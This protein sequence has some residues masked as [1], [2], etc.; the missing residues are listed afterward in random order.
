MPINVTHGLRRVRLV[1]PDRTA[2]L[3]PTFTF[4]DL[5][6]PDHLARL[7]HAVFAKLDLSSFED[8]IR[9]VEGHQGRALT[10]PHMLLTLWCFAISQGVTSAREIFHLT[11]EHAAYRWITSDLPVSHEKLSAF[12]VDHRAQLQAVFTDVLATLLHQGDLDLSLLGQD[13][14]RTRAA[15]SA[16]SFRTLGGLLHCQQQAAL[17]LKAVLAAADDPE[18][19]PAQHRRRAVM[20]RDFQARVDQALVTVKVLHEARSKPDKVVR[21]STTDPEARLMKMGDAGYRPAYNIQYSVAGSPMGGPRTIVAVE[22]TNVG[23]DLGSLAPLTKQVAERTGMLPE[24]LLADGGHVKHADVIEVEKMGVAVLMPP[25][26][27]AKP[28]SEFGGAAPELVTWRKRM[29]TEA[30]QKEYRARAGLCE[31]VNA[32]QK[33]HQGLEQVLVR[34]LGKV[35]CVALLSALTFNLLQN[36]GA[37]TS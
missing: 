23:S 28:L 19:T 29:E 26:D 32:H 14:T 10:S 22:V 37:L 7:L 25:P 27:N 12:R 9:S 30:A 15:A 35:T 16:P 21:A 24:H 8:G 3:P 4:D 20:A 13:G 11:H 18:Y 34:G 6:P 31:L 17:H 33:E 5:L 1:E 36:L 2:R